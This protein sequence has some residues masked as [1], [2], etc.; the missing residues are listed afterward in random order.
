MGEQERTQRGRRAEE[1][2]RRQADK[3]GNEGEPGSYL[4]E[5]ILLSA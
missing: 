5:S 1:G 2:T 3:S 4:K